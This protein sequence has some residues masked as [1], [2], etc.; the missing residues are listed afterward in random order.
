MSIKLKNIGAQLVMR[1]KRKKGGGEELSGGSVLV[2]VNQKFV[3]CDRA[4]G[5]GDTHQ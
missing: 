3:G 2:F 1:M 5:R 4:E